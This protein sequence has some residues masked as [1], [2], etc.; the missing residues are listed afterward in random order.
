MGPLNGGQ[1]WVA[2]CYCSLNK[3][4]AAWMFDATTCDAMHLPST[5]V[6]SIEAILDLER[7]LAHASLDSHD[8]GSAGAGSSASGYLINLLRY[9]VFGKR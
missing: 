1:E 6:I 5:P 9:E 4:A 2:I 8:V 3:T 7:L